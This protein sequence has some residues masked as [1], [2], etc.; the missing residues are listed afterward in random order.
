M[1]NVHKKG[2]ETWTKNTG[3]GHVYPLEQARRLLPRS[4]STRAL[5]IQA[6]TPIKLHT[7]AVDPQ[8]FYLLCTDGLAN[9]LSDDDIKHF[10]DRLHDGSMVDLAR[11]LIEPATARGGH[12]NVSVV[13]ATLKNIRTPR[14]A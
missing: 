1:F 7:L 8:D 13:L 11:A 12:D 14:V 2:Q 5:S 3:S 4:Y 10:F 6:D 9:L